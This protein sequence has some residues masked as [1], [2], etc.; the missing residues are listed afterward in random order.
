MLDDFAKYGYVRR[1][2]LDIV[3]LPIGPDIAEQIGLPADYGILIERV[4][5]GGAAEKAGLQGGT[6]RAYQGNMPVMLGGDL[7]IAMDGQEITSPQDLSA[8]MNSHRAGDDGHAHGLPWTQA[9]WTSRSRWATRRDQQ[10]RGGQTDTSRAAKLSP[11]RCLIGRDEIDTATRDAVLAAKHARNRLGISD[12]LLLQDPC[13]QRLCSIVVDH[14][15]CLL[16]NDHAVVD[17]LVDKVHR[18]T[19]DLRPIFERLMLRIE[20]RKRRQQRRMHIQNAIRKRL[21]KRRRDNAHIARQADEIDL[22]LMQPR[23]HL[24]I[25]LVALASG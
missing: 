23:D 10:G 15:H 20:P 3:T 6:Q 21:Y 22:V 1:P 4:L 25:M 24:R 9:R 13:R 14:R 7:I 18:A 12:V 8:A 19:G 5:P 2:T 17:G 16:Q 11:D